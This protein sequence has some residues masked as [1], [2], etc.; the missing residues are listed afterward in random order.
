VNSGPTDAHDLVL[1]LQ[2]LGRHDT[3][4][5]T[6]QWTCMTDDGFGHV[7]CTLPVLAAGATSSPIRFGDGWP[8]WAS[9]T[10]DDV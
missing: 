4:V 7:T 6:G 3:P 9:V 8:A 5:D 1:R 2:G 10:A